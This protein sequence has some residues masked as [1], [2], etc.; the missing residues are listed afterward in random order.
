MRYPPD[1]GSDPETRRLER[2]GAEAVKRILANQGRSFEAVCATCGDQFMAP[3]WED[4]ENTLC[5][6]CAEDEQNS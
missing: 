4:P 6:P 5:V 2:E 1:T 3:S